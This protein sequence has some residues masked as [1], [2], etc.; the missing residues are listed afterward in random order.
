MISCEWSSCNEDATHTVSIYFPDWP[1][2]TWRVCRQHDRDLKTTAVRS[3][4][5]ASPREGK[6][7]TATVVCSDCGTTI[8]EEAS[9]PADRRQPCSACG[10]L[11]RTINL[12]IEETVTVHSS[13]RLKKT[14]G[15]KGAWMVRVITGDD[16]TR[17][18][19]AWGHRELT[20]D[21]GQDQYGEVIELHDG[22]RI[23]SSARLRDHCD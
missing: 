21:R 8:D 18:L 1:A 14:R 17:D 23:A 20:L 16:Y 5:K 10:S 3:R 22:T 11:R 2:E 7:P 6:S 19:D 9:T 12:L 4:P 13:L 15:D